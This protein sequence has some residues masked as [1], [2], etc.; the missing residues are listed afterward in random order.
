MPRLLATFGLALAL[1]ACATT[2]ATRQT[3]VTVGIA[4]INDFHGNLEPPKQSALLPDGQGG[5]TAVP[6][7]GAAWL[8]STIEAVRGK[9]PNH[10]TISAGDLIGSSPLTSSLF[11]D[12]PTIEVMNRI[13]LDFN[14]VGNHEFDSGV[15]E[16]RRKQAGGCHQFTARKPCQLE[17]FR[18]AQFGFLAANVI[19]KD[20]STLFPATAMRSF[21]TGRS[22]V[23]IG[24]IG[25][26]LKGTGAL[27]SPAVSQEVRFMDEADT[28]NALVGGLKKQGADAVI[29]VI[30]QGGRTTGEPDPN[31][32]ENLNAEIRPILDRLDPRV[33][34][35]V[36]GHTHWS[37][38]CD[39]ADYNK[40]KPFLLTSAGLWGEF[41][42]DIA[43][44]ID[45]VSRKV[46]AKR[47]RNV[48]V[49]SPAYTSPLRRVAN[50]DAFPRYEPRA[51]IAAYVAR[52]VD[53]AKDFTLRKVGTLARAAEKNTGKEASSG[54]VL[55]NLIA[56]AQLAA[57]AGAGAQIAC[58]N[59]FG[60]RRSLIPLDDGS[61]TF[62]DL[63]L[64]Q[65][66]NSQLETLSYTGAELKAA[67]EQ[68]FDADGPEQ[69]L[70]CSAG[71]HFSYD[72]TRPAGDRIVDMLLNGAKVD[73]AKSYR[74]TVNSF[75]AN[76]GD[77]YYGFT[78]GRDMVL[79][80]T[81][82]VALEA[83]LKAVPPRDPPQEKRASDLHPDT[84]PTNLRPPPGVEY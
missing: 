79:G 43:L 63:Y 45:P 41:V 62:G 1:G 70:A 16:L 77:T 38:V 37:Y 34:V 52:Y 57:T 11:L 81:D 54:G 65:P 75:L 14:A 78:A 72:R 2:S 20:G 74:V 4:A 8:A 46:V 40:A 80:V 42:T 9:Y 44:E 7:G 35:V 71:F 82:I 25:M 60:I 68:G 27:S 18:G 24:L 32:C 76:G 58:T 49:Q 21:G 48:V 29:L 22:R 33:D 84:N 56:D 10:L 47:A 5:L 12:E 31:G 30:H 55:G 39:Y 51:D 3:A 69:V 83:W 17:P 36:S 28:A 64:V 23:K 50:T 26:T 59:P 67:L 53:A 61:V 6:A 73:P 66:F 13:G 19:T 15:D